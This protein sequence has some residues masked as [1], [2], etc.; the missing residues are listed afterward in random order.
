M[1]LP[2]SCEASYLPGFLSEEESWALFHEIYDN[3]D[4]SPA[5]I[6]TQNGTECPQEVG[7]LMFVE[8]RLTDPELF[9][10]AHGRRVPWPRLLEDVMKRAAG[11]TGTTYE[12]CVCIHYPDGNAGVAFHSDFPAFG[13]TSSIAS[14]SLGAERRLALREKNDWSNEHV[15]QLGHGSLLFMGRHCQDRYE[16]ALLMDEECKDP[17]INLTFRMFGWRQV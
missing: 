3:Y 13:D 11:I 2:L 1:R 15:V 5:A 7:K 6:T 9:P 10:L 14:V 12:V 8:P 4:I 16:H 17:R